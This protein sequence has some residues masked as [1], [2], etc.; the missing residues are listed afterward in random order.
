[1][2]SGGNRIIIEEFPVR[3]DAEVMY[4]KDCRDGHRGD[5]HKIQDR[6]YVSDHIMDMHWN[7]RRKLTV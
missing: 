5:V 4:T 1:M 7:Q 6:Q 2:V 3:V